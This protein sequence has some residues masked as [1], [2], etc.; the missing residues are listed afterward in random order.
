[1]IEQAG[2]KELFE[3][4]TSQMASLRRH[5]SLQELNKKASLVKTLGQKLLAGGGNSRQKNIQGR[6]ERIWWLNNRKKNCVSG[7]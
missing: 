7:I 4:S 1:M 5:W 6:N 2:R 3:K